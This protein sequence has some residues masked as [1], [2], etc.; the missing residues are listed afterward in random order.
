MKIAQEDK[1]LMDKWET[2]RTSVDKEAL[3]STLRSSNTW[4][5][6]NMYRTSSQDM[7]LDKEQIGVKGRAIPGYS[8]YVPGRNETYGLQ[9]TFT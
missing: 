9:Q 7:R 6:N 5:R 1:T 4:A 2:K 8:G 3:E